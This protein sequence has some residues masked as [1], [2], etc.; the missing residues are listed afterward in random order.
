MK[1]IKERRQIGAVA[2]L[3]QLYDH[4]SPEL[5][6]DF[7]AVLV[8]MLVGGVA[9]LGTIG[10]VVPFLALLSN[11][12]PAR[13]GRS[14]SLLA[15]LG[16]TIGIGSATAAG[17]VLAGF[18]IFAGIIRISLAWR[19][20]KFIYGLAHHL[21]LQSLQKMLSQPYSF[22]VQRELGALLSTTVKVEIVVFDVILPA[23]QTLIAVF[24]ACFLIAGLIY[25]DP[26]TTIATA[27]AFA[28][29]YVLA[30]LVTRKRLAANSAVA[31]KAYNDRH[32][33]TDESLAGIRDVIIDNSQ[34]IHVGLFNRA[35]GRLARARAVT[36]FIAASPRFMIETL[37][38]VLIA[39]IAVILSGREGGIA[40][41][42]PFLG[43]LALGAQ[44]LLPLVQTVYNGWSLGAGNRSI[45]NQVVELLNLPDD[46]E[47]REVPP[48]LPFRRDISFDSVSFSYPGR[49]K[50]P[51]LHDLSF[52][53]PAGSMVAITGETGAGKS[54]VADLLMALLEPSTG[55]ILVDGAPLTAR[56]AR[57]WQRNIAH[58]PQTIF[59]ADTTIARNIAIALADEPL[60]I[61]RVVAAAQQAQID[62]F[63][64]TLPRKY[65]TVVGERGT[66]LSGGQRQ[67]LA[68][69]RAIYKQAP[70]LV[71]D[72]A[73]SALD[74]QTEAAVIGAL[75]E[76]RR[77]G[78]TI[79][80]I[81][82]RGSTVTACDMVVRLHE[83]RIVEAGPSGKLVG[84]TPRNRRA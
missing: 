67:R 62:E 76:L 42:I 32:K 24:I 23:M 41:A 43:A 20:H 1:L 78:R 55:Q 10:S 57:S 11:N 29:I 79:I 84:G 49:S 83:G 63:I 44:R 53:I 9:E 66:R 13:M 58:V 22:H 51:A 77:E 47:H 71:L 33:I 59:L 35:S 27:A 34:S 25:I 68:L 4:L 15:T 64:A 7:F 48:P 69:A 2:T 50:T 81:A 5:R 65:D 75:E 38:T 52:T 36:A 30:S 21:A 12:A 45:I 56:N 70:V 6:R 40:M 61:E 3:W 54:T 19:T 14:S 80:I 74:Y 82:H 39:A 60:D 72:E 37:G 31:E 8:L 17:I 18:A 26:T 16:D 28:A 73:T 46:C